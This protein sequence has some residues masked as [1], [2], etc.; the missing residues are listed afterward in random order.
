[1][2]SGGETSLLFVG[3]T[4]ARYDE[5]NAALDKGGGGFEGLGV[6]GVGVGAKEE[7]N[8]SKESSAAAV[9]MDETPRA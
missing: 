1:M 6:V 2:R 5:D 9:V 8:E 4:G 3:T 7:K